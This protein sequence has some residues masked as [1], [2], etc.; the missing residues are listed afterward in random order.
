MITRRR[1]LF[2]V[3][4]AAALV[5]SSVA[6]A[7]AVTTPGD[8]GDVEPL[9]V[10]VVGESTTLTGIEVSGRA[11][12][13]G[14][15]TRI[16]D[17][18]PSAIENR[19]ADS[20]AS[21][22]E[23]RAFTPDLGL[24]P[25]TLGEMVVPPIPDALYAAATEDWA[26]GFDPYLDGLEGYGVW[27]RPAGGAAELLEIPAAFGAD[28]GSTAIWGDTALVGNVLINLNT[29]EIIV[30]GLGFKK[31]CLD[32]DGA[33][34][35][36]GVLLAYD[37]CHSTVVA[38]DVPS[39]GITVAALEDPRVVI[40][41]GAEL[42]ALSRGLVV[43]GA[44]DDGLGT[45]VVR[46]QRL[47]DEVG[48]YR[49]VS[50]P[51]EEL[52]SIRVHGERFVLVFS[53]EGGLRVDVFETPT[54]EEG[55]LATFVA[56]IGDL[57][58]AVVSP[59]LESTLDPSSGM[60]LDYVPIDLFGRTLA[61]QDGDTI[62]TATLPV[63][64]GGGATMGAPST[65]TIGATVTVT[66]AGYLPSEEVAVWLTSDPVLLT[67]GYAAADGTF[68]ATVTLPAGTVAGAHTLTLVGVESGWTAA[69]AITLAAASN[70]GLLV[71][72]GR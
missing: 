44:Y 39:D 26:V 36:D 12:T 62:L 2:A 7:S 13:W 30:P 66:G 58:K 11:I 6:T 52:Q 27:I 51:E 19:I 67:T 4:A 18:P 72:T 48:G 56:E 54:A 1:A 69:A 59:M 53:D 49:Q 25:L 55:P 24:S 33:A 64:S 38:V 50:L 43:W 57:K 28:A 63:L 70:P 10:A 40:D 60:S 37:R 5:L 14:S 34:L 46:W 17:S 65:G 16:A 20:P 35:A 32:T 61:W 31:V 22:I 3:P 29:R 23:A 15:E 9:E 21:A 42:L 8:P 45:P 41:D 71:D 68:S 47:T